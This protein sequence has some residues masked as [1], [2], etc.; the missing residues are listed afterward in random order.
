MSLC[1]TPVLACLGLVRAPRD[2]PAFDYDYDYVSDEDDGDDSD[3][4]GRVRSRLR[5]PS[6]R[7]TDSWW[8]RLFRRDGRAEGNLFVREGAG[9]DGGARGRGHVERQPTTDPEQ[10]DDSNQTSLRERDDEE[11]LLG[12]GFAASQQPP[13]P[14]AFHDPVSPALGTTPTPASIFSSSGVALG[15]AAVAPSATST[16]SS[17]SPTKRGLNQAKQRLIDEMLANDY[18]TYASDS[19]R[20]RGD[21]DLVGS[22]AG[23]TFGQWQSEPPK[24]LHSIHL[25]ESISHDLFSTPFASAHD[26]DLPENADTA[27]MRMPA[28]SSVTAIDDLWAGNP[29]G[30]L[31]E[32]E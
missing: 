27:L 30:S 24:P 23:D 12:I 22:D 6:L 14:L 18:A 3:D 9:E 15:R 13:P 19:G 16:T 7:A 21:V 2:V 31:D 25:P 1:C 5:A 20:V 8:A 26:L 29:L 4:V 10:E 32:D 28:P 17:S 11:D